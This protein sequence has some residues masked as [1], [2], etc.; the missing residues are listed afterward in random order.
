MAN[1]NTDYQL[2][3]K[4]DLG[5]RQISPS[6]G[7]ILAVHFPA[8]MDPAQMQAAA[9]MMRMNV[10]DWGINLICLTGGVQAYGTD[11]E[12]LLKVIPKEEMNKLGWYNLHDRTV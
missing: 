10:E 11:L 3:E 4:A 6:K 5:I 1:E 12:T 9:E 7:D 2:Y 8:D